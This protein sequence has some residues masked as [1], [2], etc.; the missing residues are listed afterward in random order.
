M[1]C[2]NCEK[3][4][5]ALS[6]LEDRAF[7]EHY[8][9]SQPTD[10]LRD[11][12]AAGFTRVTLGMLWDRTWPGRKPNPLELTKLGRTLDAL[13]WRRTKYNGLLYFVIPDEV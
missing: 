10:W 13:G 2:P 5:A 3:L 11:N 6:P 8:L 9:S 12:H 1:N 4:R 7:T